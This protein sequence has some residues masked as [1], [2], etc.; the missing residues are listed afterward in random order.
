MFQAK[1]DTNENL[2]LDFFKGIL[3]ASLMSLGLVVLAAFCLKW[4]SIEDSFIAPITLLI[5][6]LSVLVGAVIA[7]KGR[8][9]GLAKGAVFGILYVVIAF[10]VFS[11][12]AGTMQVGVSTFLD[13]L[14]ASLLGG[15][16][17]IVKVN[18]A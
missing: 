1:A 16:V 17:G 13:V 14:F 3:V 11:F 5:K 8:S 9:N 2:F 7:V 6:G 12:L 15:I 4:F 10:V 18:R